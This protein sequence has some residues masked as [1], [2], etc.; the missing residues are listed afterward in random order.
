MVGSTLRALFWILVTVVI[1][2]V[3]VGYMVI[4]GYLWYLS[5]WWSLLGV[6]MGIAYAIFI[7][8][9]MWF[10]FDLECAYVALLAMFALCGGGFLPLGIYGTLS[11]RQLDRHGHVEQAT[12]T[13]RHEIC[14]KIGDG[15]ICTNTYTLKGGS[16]SPIYLASGKY[17]RIGQR[18]AVEI[19]PEK[20][21][22]P[23]LAKPRLS[24][25]DIS[26]CVVL[27][28]LTGVG[29]VAYI[30]QALVYW[31]ELNLPRRSS[32]ASSYPSSRP[33]R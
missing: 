30:R 7:G 14:N 32:I 27:V 1:W 28:L 2:F 5:F 4:A 17:L 25:G 22:L 11:H 6:L 13:T 26:F 18:V 9:S 20:H 16:G 24:A 21:A 8:W 12:V 10:I 29:V 31:P 15:E 19:D 3:L 33:R 23:V